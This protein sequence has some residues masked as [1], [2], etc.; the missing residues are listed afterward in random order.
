MVTSLA[1]AAIR[2]RGELPPG[3]PVLA[4]PLQ[5]KELHALLRARIGVQPVR[6]AET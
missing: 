3:I 5:F 4:K 2:E 6:P 1:G